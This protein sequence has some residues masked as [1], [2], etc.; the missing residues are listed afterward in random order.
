MDGTPSS[1]LLELRSVTKRYGK[2]PALVGLDLTLRRG[3]VYGLLGRNGA[4][5]STALRIVM[6][7]TRPDAGTVALFGEAA[8]PGSVR[9]RQR[10]GYVAQEQHFYEWMTPERLGRF[11]GGFYPTFR[12]ERYREL[13]GRFEVPAR[14]VGTF[15][16]G[17]KV[18][19]ALA[20]AL[21]PSPELLVLDEPT[22]GLDAVAR[23]EFLDIVREQAASGQYSTL[24][25]S[26]LIDDVELVSTQ[27]GIIENGRMQYE[28][29]LEH[30]RARVR[31]VVLRSAAE[32][33]AAAPGWSA[34]AERGLTV[35]SDR[36]LGSERSVM[37]WA[38]DPAAFE[39]L[40]ASW[41]GVGLALEWV[42]L[43]E[44][45]IA[46]VRARG[47]ATSTPAA[48]APAA[49]ATSEATSGTLAATAEATGATSGVAG[50][51]ESAGAGPSAPSGS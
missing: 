21:A 50:T 40:A 42:P 30:L 27:V 51:S 38:D 20:L 41:S 22:T 29:S 8:K 1:S 3:Q 35:L 31:R 13:L 28:G 36:A 12:E 45:F 47:V 9:P 14:R 23:R 26:H 37:L 34:L 25:S 19:L 33:Q 46:L 7:I 44:A 32:V 18:K 15:S 17:T 11:V 43:E 39:A 10:I 49:A 24:F 48:A 6:G 5:K 16:G 4:G 2:V